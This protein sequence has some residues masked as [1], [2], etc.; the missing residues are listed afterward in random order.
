[1]KDSIRKK[2]LE[3]RQC[4][5]EE[6]AM[7]KS[8]TISRKAFS[9]P[10]IQAARTVS[11]YVGTGSE[12]KTNFLIEDL[13]EAGKKV[14]VPAAWL[15]KEMEMRCILSLNDLQK[16]NRF[17]EPKDCCIKV[18]DC[19]E[20]SAIIVPGTAFDKKGNRLGYGKGYYDRYLAKLP[21]KTPIIGLAFECQLVE[22]IPSEK[23]DIKVHKIV[24]EKRIIK[25][26]NHS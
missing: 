13:L 24:T 17:F 22:K 4:L 20:I 10:E 9:L 12:V 18:E 2:A 8:K 23:H 26:K 3:K 19:K 15:E 16:K 1:M 14:V 25:C 6:Q 21:K 7:Q 11:C 5:S